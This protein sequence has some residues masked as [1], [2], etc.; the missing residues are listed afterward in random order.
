MHFGIFSY[1]ATIIIFTGLVI[2]I[3]FLRGTHRLPPSH[4]KIISLVIILGSL[5]TGATER[6]ALTWRTWIYNPER[7]LY[8]T[9]LGAEI[10]T[11]L[12]A[13]LVSFVVASATLRRA[14]KEEQDREMRR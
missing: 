6:V 3:R 5:F 8:T 14:Q 7:T 4:W 9:F 10:E 1:T 2:L 11:Y 12:F 13:L